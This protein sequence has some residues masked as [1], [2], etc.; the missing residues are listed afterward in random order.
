[1]ERES[2]PKDK[3]GKQDNY[4]YNDPMGWVEGRNEDTKTRRHE[5]FD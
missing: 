4:I 1:M 5:E 3:R 2:R